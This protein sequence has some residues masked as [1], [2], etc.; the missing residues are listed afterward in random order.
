MWN[1]VDHFY[2]VSFSMCYL[3]RFGNH[4]SLAIIAYSERQVGKD[5]KNAHQRANQQRKS[6]KC[7]SP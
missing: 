6:T 5:T 1:D 7:H 2:T 4:V 3:V